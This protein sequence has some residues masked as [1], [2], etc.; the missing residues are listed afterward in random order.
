M[1]LIADA[2]AEKNY[3]LA[4]EI[5]SGVFIQWAK[6]PGVKNIFCRVYVP[7]FFKICLHVVTVNMVKYEEQY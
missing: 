2:I 3:N 5:L 6:T 1:G 4:L 7:R